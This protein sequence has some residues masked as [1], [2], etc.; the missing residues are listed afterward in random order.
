MDF[1]GWLQEISGLGLAFNR[2]S[3]MVRFAM[4]DSEL[5]K[6]VRNA[7]IVLAIVALATALMLAGVTWPLWFLILPRLLGA[8]VMLLFTLIQH[9]EMQENSPSILDST[10]SFRATWLGRFLYANM[11]NHIENH[12]YPQ[13]PFYALPQLHEAVKEQLPEPDP[14]FLRTNAEVLSV[15]LRRFMGRGAEAASIRQVPHMATAGLERIAART[16]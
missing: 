13:V 10:R 8:P 3:E 14:D 16:M 2:P 12:L 1:R 7:R 4:L 5:L 11:N 15:V 9:V 6:L